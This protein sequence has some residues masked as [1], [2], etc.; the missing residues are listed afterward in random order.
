MSNRNGIFLDIVAP[1][2]SA[3]LGNSLGALCGTLE[4]SRERA[5]DPGCWTQGLVRWSG[6]GV[7]M[8]NRCVIRV[9]RV[10]L[11]RPDKKSFKDLDPM[12]C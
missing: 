4:L 8:W 7:T 3:I 1:R 6:N 9:E 2:L 12:C 11:F 5:R 10:G